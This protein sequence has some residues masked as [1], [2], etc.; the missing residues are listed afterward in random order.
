MIAMQ[1]RA[2]AQLSVAR[3]PLVRHG[4]LC[5][6]A[7]AEH[8]FLRLAETH[9]AAFYVTLQAAPALMAA[10]PRRSAAPRRGQP[11][12]T[13]AAASQGAEQPDSDGQRMKRREAP[14]KSGSNSS[15]SSS[16]S[17]EEA[18]ELAVSL[19]PLAALAGMGAGAAKS[20]VSAV[21]GLPPK[22]RQLVLEHGYA[23]AQLLLAEGVTRR[24]LAALLTTCPDQFAW[25]AAGRGR[26]PPR[27]EQLI[28]E[29]GL[30]ATD[31]ARCFIEYPAAARA[32]HDV[33]RSRH[34]GSDPGQP[35]AG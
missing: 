16:L 9:F 7:A 26:L 21:A 19:E 3:R 15:K 13:W 35:A 29:L 23:V 10:A 30:T 20:L 17:G 18:A 1:C 11:V 33:F 4:R 2:S 32:G 28:Q 34:R 31:V 22:A 25:P 8:L 27:F 12:V 5:P 14:S 6:A 24:Q